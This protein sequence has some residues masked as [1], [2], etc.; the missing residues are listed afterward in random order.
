ML[1]RSIIIGAISM[2]PG[3]LGVTEGSLTFMLVQKGVSNQYAVASTFIIRAVTLWFA[4]LIG[5]ISVSIY[6]KRFG[7]IIIEPE[8]S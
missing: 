5:V 7:K 1:F 3:G 2:L 8:K 6:Q 4:V